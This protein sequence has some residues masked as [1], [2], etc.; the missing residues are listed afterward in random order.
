MDVTVL[1]TS[2][3]W[4]SAG[5][6]AA[7]FLVRHGDAAMALDLG[8]GA[9]SNLQLEVPHE[10]LDAVAITHR[11]VDHCLDLASLTV[12][13]VF[14]PEPLPP[15]PYFAPIGVFDRVSALE[16]ADERRQMEALFDV[17]DLDGGDTFEVGPFRITARELPH[18]VRNLGYRVEAGGTSLAYT[19]DAGPSKEIEVLAKDVNLLVSEASWE[20]EDGILVEG[21]LTARQAAGHASEASAGALL[22]THFWPTVDRDRARELAAA[23]FDGDVLVAEERVTIRVGS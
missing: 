19:G 4:P 9:L 13:R 1:G 14:H 20:D 17:H 12:A 23:V 21:H 10:R 11:H 2:A 6:A 22:L 8:T 18:M 5:R 15:L 3:A 16:S 7:G